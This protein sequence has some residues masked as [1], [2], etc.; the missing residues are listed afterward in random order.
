MVKVYTAPDRYNSNQVK[1]FLAGSIEQGKA[2]N[3]QKR[4]INSLSK[5]EELIIFNPRR[6]NWTNL[7]Q[8]N[9]K[10]QI[11]W[12]LNYL[13]ESDIVFFYFDPSTI[14]PVS[15]LELGLFKDKAIVCCPKEYFRYDN[16]KAVCNRYN[17]KLNTDFKV[18]LLLLSFKINEIRHDKKR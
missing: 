17:I 18:T 3:W 15:L 9:L 5:E 1:L 8:K 13:E 12:E 10:E 14:S 2:E 7:D 11:N 16:V 6:P 4:A